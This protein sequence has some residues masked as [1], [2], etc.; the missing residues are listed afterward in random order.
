MSW[1]NW[2]QALSNSGSWEKFRSK[3]RSTN[4]LMISVSL[5][6]GADQYNWS[7]LNWFYH[8]AAEAL[9]GGIV[10][11]GLSNDFLEEGV[12]RL[13]IPWEGNWK[14]GYGIK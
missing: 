8:L 3:R 11:L 10:S 6:D 7:Y 13:M 9:L 5:N 1:S 14:D 2:V 4:I 12:P